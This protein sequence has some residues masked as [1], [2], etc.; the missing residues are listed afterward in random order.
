[1]SLLE[2]GFS[3][4]FYY[5]RLSIT[6]VCNFRCTYCLPDGYRPEGRKSFLSVEEIRR[7]VGGFAAMGTRKVR[8]TG[9]EPSLR[10]DFTSIIEAV[11]STP[12]IEK[13]AMTTNGYR[14]KERA[15]E[16]FEAGLSALNVSVD[17]LDP[18]QFHQITGENKLA[19][20]ME[21]IETAL[22]AGFKSVKI[23][24]VLLKGLNDYQLEAFLAWIKH[25][26]IE[27]RFIELMQTGE[28]D[29]L[30]QNHHVS[31]EQ[32]KQR[33]LESG[34]VQQ[35]RGKDDGPAQVFMHPESQGGVG[36]I[37]PYSKD[38]CAGCNRLRVSSVGKLHLCLFG[39]N[40]VELRDLLGAD[41]QQE[42]LQQRIRSALS[43]K[44]ATHRLHE[45]NAGATPHLASIGG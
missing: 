4:R 39:D 34:W 36:L 2:D 38:F 5:L 6:D 35:L 45:G 10:R 21:G 26:P 3:R 32:I 42:A 9:G 28:M 25:K 23:N 29:T 11:A 44:A 1:M 7:V 43:G 17:S 27:L 41:G 8:L 14:L 19:E 37:M 16:W 18:R 30:F 24:A 22:A 31:G 33:L 15:S 40:G 12:G 13:V 20:V